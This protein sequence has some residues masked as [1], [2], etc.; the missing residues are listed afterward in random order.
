VE[1]TETSG[2]EKVE[3]RRFHRVIQVMAEGDR[4]APVFDSPGEKGS[5]PHF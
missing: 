3:Q 1:A 2:V 5:R 4:R